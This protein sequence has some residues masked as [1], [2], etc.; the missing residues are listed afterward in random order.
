M[1]A[2]KRRLR[3]LLPLACLLAVL[4]AGIG[5]W[6]SRA[7]QPPQTVSVVRA[8]IEAG[9]TAT[10]TLQPLRYVDV[11]AQVSGV[12]LRLHV[13]PGDVVVKG[14]LLVEIDPSVQQAVVDAGRAALADLRA[15]LIEQRTQHQLADRQLARQRQLVADEATRIEDLETAEAAQAGAAA[16]IT[17]LEARIERA[18][19]TQR[20]EETRLG[21][22]RI[23][24]PMAGTVVAVEPREGQTLNA[25]YQTPHIL[26]IADLSAMTVW[27]KVSEADVR[28][29][30][31]GMPVWFTTLDDV[32][33]QAGLPPRRW[34]ATVRQVLPAPPAPERR[35]GDNESRANA[36]SSQVV[37]YTALFDVD[38]ADGALM[39]QMTA[40]VTFVAAQATTVLAAPMSALRPLPGEPGRFEARVLDASGRIEVRRVRIGT[41]DRVLGEV[42]EGLEEGERLVV[43]TGA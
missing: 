16:R 37:V 42:R 18:R 28:A 32:T 19:A 31:A 13:Q 40:Q 39:P 34:S 38:N 26:R 14:Q 29:V 10:G 9:I 4:A 1:H 5:W 21:Y 30:K 12:I 6:R 17:Q 3:W 2:S 20:A 8:D 15:Q 24:A 23:H 22:A 25:T 36:S 33:G 27:T 41:T 35:P 11:G 7:A 43:G